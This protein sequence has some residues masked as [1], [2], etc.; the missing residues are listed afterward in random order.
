MDIIILYMLLFSYF[1]GL[2]VYRFRWGHFLIMLLR[3][4][5]ITLSIYLSL[6]V[7][8]NFNSLNLFFLIIYLRM[9]V[10]EGVLGLRIMVVSVRRVGNEYIMSINSLW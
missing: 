9:A 3:L 1:R 6:F 2:V 8:I 10:C 5:F 4:E 7:I